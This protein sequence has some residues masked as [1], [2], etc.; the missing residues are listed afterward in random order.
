VAIT[1]RLF[2]EFYVRDALC[3]NPTGGHDTCADGV[4]LVVDEAWLEAVP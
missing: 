2:E 4:L 3:H 1:R